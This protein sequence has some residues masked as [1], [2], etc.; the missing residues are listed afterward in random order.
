MEMEGFR[1]EEDFMEDGMRCIPMAARLR[2]DL[3]GV[4]L[5]LSEW[6]R[7]TVD[8][9]RKVASWNYEIP[10]E[11]DACRKYLEA[12]VLR[13]T[14]KEATLLPVTGT[15][16]WE[17]ISCVPGAVEEK[18]AEFNWTLSVKEWKSLS[19]L[20]RFALVKLARPGHENRNFPRAVIEF[21]QRNMIP[22]I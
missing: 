12:I 5:R 22:V 8:E 4:K 17:D 2:L 19:E 10:R 15:Y 1:F 21:R 20:Q 3:C 9:R 11:M 18:M 7:M 16:P 13:R 6:S 14:G